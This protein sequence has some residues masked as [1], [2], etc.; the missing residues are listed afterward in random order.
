MPSKT[1]A[2][3]AEFLGSWIDYN[4]GG[5]KSEAAKFLDEPP[6]AV[7]DV[8]AGRRNPTVSMLV[9]TGSIKKTTIHYEGDFR[10]TCDRIKKTNIQYKRIR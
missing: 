6:S 9:E 10:K 3:F 1:K 5:N 2:Q 7:Y 8:L 4:F